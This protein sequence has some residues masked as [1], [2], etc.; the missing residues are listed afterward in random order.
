MVLSAT[1]SAWRE[2]GVLLRDLFEILQRHGLVKS[3]T[4]VDTAFTRKPISR[5]V[6]ALNEVA[7]ASSRRSKSS[8]LGGEYVHSA[9]L[10]LGGAP[11]LCVAVNCRTEK[12]RRLAEFAA[13]Y[14]D[15]VYAYN[16]LADHSEEFGHPPR[17]DDGEFRKR[18]RDDVA[19]MCSLKP[20][21]DAGLVVPFLPEH[22]VCTTC[23]VTRTLGTK[24]GRV[25]SRVELD[26]REECLG[27]MQIDVRHL[28][29]RYVLECSGVDA[30]AEHGRQ[31]FIKSTPFPALDQRP[32]LHRQVLAGQVVRAS[33]SLRRELGVHRRLVRG[34]MSSVVHHLNV[35]AEQRSQFLTGSETHVRVLRKLSE[36]CDDSV[37][38][39]GQIELVVPF[40]RDVPLGAL[41]K[42]RKREAEAFVRFRGALNRAVSGA[43]GSGHRSRRDLDAVY[44]DVLHPEL[45]R[46]QGRVREAKRD[47]I[48][49]PLSA[50]VGV[51]AAVTVGV[52]SG[53]LGGPIADIAQ[54]LGLTKVLGDTV[55]EAVRATDVRKSVRS[56]EMYFLWRARR[57]A[58]S[59]GSR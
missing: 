26:L 49:K 17:R 13:L 29:G 35:C 25:A 55:T 3:G 11:V 34:A 18:V 51:T 57:L 23:A 46:L 4:P 38:W 8:T 44:R 6:G 47:L 40:V 32:R 2:E 36:Q 50:A 31:I 48:L 39:S 22:H 20:V 53:L 14:S 52:Y 58:G 45:A 28:H 24:S 21:I 42:L 43:M 5:L 9:S 7:R 56:E 54:A 16:F 59:T 41:V 19:V 33:P 15:R 12:V 1:D 30:F 37:G 27:G 10:D